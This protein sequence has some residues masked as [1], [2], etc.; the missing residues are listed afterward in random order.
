MPACRQ[1][2][3]EFVPRSPSQLYCCPAC[4]RLWRKEHKGEPKPEQPVRTFVCANPHCH[5]EVTTAGGTDKRTRF[6]S[7]R[8]EKYYWRHYYAKP[9]QHSYSADELKRT[10][11][12]CRQEFTASIPTQIFCCKS[13]A[14]KYNEMYGAHGFYRLS[15]ICD[16]PKCKNHVL[17]E[18]GRDRRYRFCCRRCY[19]SFHNGQ[20]RNLPNRSQIW[21]SAGHYAS[22]ERMTNEECD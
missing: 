10:C 4:G 15:Y 12:W 8:C 7:K 5:K 11:P 13:C 3:K 20:P 14:G 18:G 22:W 21:R 6:C 9:A 16:N 19:I 1:C 17:T 2:G